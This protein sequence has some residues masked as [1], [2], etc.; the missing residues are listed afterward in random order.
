MYIPSFLYSVVSITDCWFRFHIHRFV[1][2]VSLD[3]LKNSINLKLL[4]NLKKSFFASNTLSVYLGTS[5]SP[6]FKSAISWEVNVLLDMLITFS[7]SVTW[8]VVSSRVDLVVG[9][10]FLLPLPR[11]V[12]L[13]G[14]PGVGSASGFWCLKKHG[15]WRT[16]Q[17][18]SHSLML[19]DYLG[20]AILVL[21]VRSLEFAIL[22]CSCSLVHPVEI[23]S[24]C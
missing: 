14:V 4:E 15:S 9:V 17:T 24:V 7:S 10:G 2:V 3:A 22:L 13:Y 21:G 23:S 11:L 16:H 5:D 18:C 1:T 6:L 8:F 20:S 19:L 12:F